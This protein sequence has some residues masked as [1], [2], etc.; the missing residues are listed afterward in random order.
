M[1]LPTQT[2]LSQILHLTQHKHLK[3]G[4]TLHAHIIKTGQ[5]SSTYIANTLINL[6]AKCQHL[7]QSNLIFQEIQEKDIV[8][9]NT[10]INA[11]SQL[12]CV[13]NSIFVINLFK[14]L[15]SQVG[16]VPDG[17]TFPGVCNAACNLLDLF[18]GQQVHSVA[19]KIGYCYDVF[20]GS[21][22]VNMYCKLGVVCDARVV[23]DRM[24]ERNSVTWASMISGY[25][26]E[27][28]VFGALGVFK[29]MMWED[30]GGVNEFVF[31]SVLSAL[32]SCDD[33]FVGKQLHCLVVKLGYSLVSSVGN[34]LVTM[35]VKCG[36]LKD[37]F[38]SFE[39]VR[40]KNSITWTAIITGLV[41]SGDSE[42]AL[43]LFSKMQFFKVEFN[44]STLVAVLNV[45][46]DSGGLELGKQVHGFLVKSGYESKIHLMTTLVGM[47]AKCCCVGDARKVFDYLQEPDIVL[48][49][50]MIGGYIEAEENEYA[51]DLYCKMQ[52]ESVMPNELT[53][54]RVL[55]ACSNLVCL[56][57]GKQIHAHTI[58]FGFG[59]EVPIGSALLMMYAKCGSL[60]D[61]NLVFR[62]MPNKDVV[63]WNSMISGLSQNGHG[64]EALNLFQEMLLE[65]TTPDSVT[66]VHILNACSHKGLVDGGWFYFKMMSDEYNITPRVEHFS[67][68]VDIL[69]RAGKLYEAK[70]LI[71]TITFDHGLH[72]WRILLSACRNYRDYELGVYAGEKLMELGSGESSTYV[73]LSGIYEVLGRREDVERVRKMM[74]LRGVSKLPGCS[75]IELKNQIHVFV[76]G[77]QLHSK[78]DH[79]RVELQALTKQ[80]KDEG[81]GEHFDVTLMGFEG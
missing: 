7:P 17:H 9:Y 55:K 1:K 60:N 42:Q 58:K 26:M 77:D 16:L 52:I 71:E 2:L 31:T 6:Y 14:L 23:F 75:W 24:I 59:L 64:H 69:T 49:T 66:F 63:S 38:M 40:D 34:A 45:C 37:A 50:S 36:I 10:L 61:G 35:Y 13:Q 47:Y 67:C 46:S 5:L 80:M 79:I 78:I 8:S 53:M 20:V 65:N 70:E 68:M 39:L 54:A 44:E 74:K 62:R 27:R 3:Q 76:V 43:S 4:Q 41:Q 18:V 72:L 30:V 28:F 12:G 81:Y 29:M 19:M 57:Q 32:T 56:D 21:S 33:V 15:L 25:A 11:H 48:W 22:L 51:I 73:L